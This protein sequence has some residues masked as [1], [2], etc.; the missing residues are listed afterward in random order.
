MISDYLDYL[1]NENTAQKTINN[2]E[3]ILKVFLSKGYDLENLEY[4][5]LDKYFSER[6]AKLKP[7]SFQLEKGVLRSFFEYL[8][9]IKGVSMKFSYTQIKRRKVK[10]Q[11]KFLTREQ[12]LLAIKKTKNPQDKLMIAL[13]FETGMRIGE[14][15]NLRDEDIIQ[16]EIRVFGKGNKARLLFLTPE[17]RE[18]LESH[19]TKGYVFKPLQTS[20]E[21][22]EKYAIDSVRKRVKKC[23]KDVGIEMHPHMLR[24][25]FGTELYKN[26]V[27]LRAIQTLMGH[28]SISTTEIYTHVTDPFLHDIYRTGMRSC[29]V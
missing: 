12:V 17:L 23:F 24:H 22:E 18:A 1:K 10:T 6:R 14:L 13:L 26:R 5:E 11:V 16:H 4:T 29:V 9:G 19:I 3:S 8:Q 7:S 2:R 21:G 15:V 20:K 25:G 27:D 28:E